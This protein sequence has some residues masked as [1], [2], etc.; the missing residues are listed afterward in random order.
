MSDVTKI[1]D[2]KT[3]VPLIWI[4][5]ALTALAGVILYITDLRSENRINAI[6]IDSVEKRQ[7][8]LEK[9]IKQDIRDIKAALDELAKR[10]HAR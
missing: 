5:I 1:I 7:D 10:G 3:K 6:R 4:F 2:E 9:D 8:T